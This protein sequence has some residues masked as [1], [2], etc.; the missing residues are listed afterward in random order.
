MGQIATKFTS[1][2]AEMQRAWQ[3]AQAD[4]DKYRQKLEA[5]GKSG[6]QSGKDI[7][8]SLAD[9][10]A[11][12][13]GLVGGLVSVTT[14]VQGVKQLYADWRNEMK[15]LGEENRKFTQDV[16]AS[17]AAMGKISYLPQIE[18]AAKGVA[19]IKREDV[20]KAIV[21]VMGASPSAKF[22]RQVA[23]GQE[24]SKLAPTGMDLGS[25]ADIVGSMNDMMPQKSPGDLLD[26]ATKMQSVMGS[27][28]EE[29][30][31]KPTLRAIQSLVTSGAVG[32]H[33]EALAWGAAA[34]DANLKP[35]ILEQLAATAGKGANP[36]ATLRRLQTD[37]A[38]AKSTLGDEA[39]LKFSQI[40]QEQVGGYTQQLR[41]AQQA[42]FAKQA[43][44]D[45]ENSE[46]GLKGMAAYSKGARR[47]V[48]SMNRWATA[49]QYEQDLVGVMM[50]AN[51]NS[52]TGGATRAG[53]ASK[54][55][56]QMI[57]GGDPEVAAIERLQTFKSRLGPVEWDDK[58]EARP[59]RFA[60]AEQKESH[61]FLEEQIRIL[62]KI[63]A[64]QNR[65]AIN[66]NA[67]V[68]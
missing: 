26:M 39:G 32:S 9:I 4:V 44:R 68:E 23:L 12:T 67:H 49:E 21:G 42:D 51:P 35:G 48:N 29:L 46:T 52:W 31:S 22:E 25:M 28:F 36:A 45:L 33:E 55:R 17:A 3:K 38:F 53:H 5:A 64:N 13:T 8:M 2:D 27:D 66:I 16:L 30:K 57:R 59:G 15:G 6:K 43:V 34:H 10:A 47:D 37:A 56:E 14:V 41:L 19:G 58:G 63:E 60:T 62:Q 18:E 24:V 1:D 65:K 11:Q 20:R 61:K 40:S 54:Y 50:E 7:S